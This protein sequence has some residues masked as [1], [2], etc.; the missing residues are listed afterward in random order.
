MKYYIELD[1]SRHEVEITE[2]ADLTKLK[3][4]SIE[5]ELD[6][7]PLVDAH[8]LS[9]SL[10]NRTYRADIS[11]DEGMLNLQLNNMQF[12]AT[13]R[14]ERRRLMD[15]LMRQSK[16]QTNSFGEVKASMPGLIINVIVSSGD[17]VKKGDNL[18]VMEAMKMENSI[19]SPVDG[20]IDKCFVK[21]DQAVNK[22][23][24]LITIK[25]SNPIS[26]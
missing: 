4:D 19:N 18:I 16:R 23:Q 24:L 8:G 21:T 20:V 15:K 22:G 25:N 13:V 6:F 2:S 5:I 3:I 12:Q 11:A 9:F 14:D 7:P 10:N 17:S 26:N 1:G